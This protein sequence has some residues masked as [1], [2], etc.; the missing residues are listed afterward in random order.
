MVSFIV[1][2]ALIYALPEIAPTIFNYV[3]ALYVGPLIG[4]VALRRNDKGKKVRRV[5]ESASPPAARN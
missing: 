3:P 1:G 2:I 5:L 4:G